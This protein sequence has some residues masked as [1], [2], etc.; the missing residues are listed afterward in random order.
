MTTIS[1]EPDDTLDAT[2]PSD[3]EVDATRADVGQGRNGASAPSDEEPE[4]SPV[5]VALAAAMPTLAAAVMVGGVFTGA[6]ARVYAAV[7]ALLGVGLAYALRRRRSAVT[8]NLAIA[9]ALFGIGLLLVMPSGIGTIGGLRGHVGRAVSDGNV[10]RPP[11]G[12][13]PGW[14]AIIGWLMGV[15][16]FVAGWLA[17]A[18]RRPAFGLLVPLPVAAIAAI[19]V[20]DAQ[21]V[22]SGIACLALFAL[23]LGFLSS[24][25]QAAS[26]DERPPLSYEVRKVAKGLPLVAVILVGLYGLAQA[27][28]LFPEPRIDPTQE[29]QKPKTV[30]LTEV[31][32]RVL[33]EVS[34]SISGPW[35]TGSL[36]IYDGKDWRLPPFAASELDEVPRSGIVDSELQP[37]VRATF[38]VAGMQGT[39]LPGLPNPV[40]I[41]A[42]GPALAFDD[43]NDSIRVAQGQVQAGLRYTVA[44][45]GLPTID[46]LRQVTFTLP[47]DMQEFTDIGPVPPAVQGLID[48][49]P[50]TSKWDEFDYLRTWILDNVTVTGTGVPK[51]VTAER[52]NDMI[53]GSQEGSPYEIVAAQAMLARWIGVPSRIGYGYDGGDLVGDNLQ[54]RPKHGSSFVEVWFPGYKWLPVIGT[55]KKAKP[56]VGDPGQQL[57][58]PSVLPSNEIG[59]QLYLPV[60]TPAPSVLA[61]QVRQVV[62]IALPILLLLGLAYVLWPA[63]YKAVLRSRRRA[64]VMRAG[65]RAR[66]ALAY[67]EWRDYATDLGFKFPTDTPLMFLDRFVDD[68]EHTQFAWLVTRALWGDLQETAGIDIATAAEELS[69]SLRRRL[70]QSQPGTVRA[71]AVV[72]RLSMRDPYAP[73]TDLTGRRE[74]P[75]AEAPQEREPVPV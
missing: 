6:G 15:T 11:V 34:S 60:L 61:D 8:I 73:E 28:I 30:P 18:V 5:R 27:D 9:V 58:D 20:P 39:T 40:G 53:G 47:E 21:Q 55:P 38:T 36:D 69:R 24:A 59:V 7:A 54:V 75:H 35:R 17:L 62:L 48:E 72:S 13:T 14:Q 56:T 29:P 10:L 71:I 37:G 66:I 63:L 42:E 68:E 45:A 2:P 64:A 4:G 19:S 43:R 57:V 1:R 52:V 32:D 41:V 51:S 49:A 22:A 16:G 70:A 46:D 44:A 50:K 12:L 33:F 26:A 31:E 67:A 25:A 23:G 65:P 74:V 3:A